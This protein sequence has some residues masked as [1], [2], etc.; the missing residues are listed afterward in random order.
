[1]SRQAVSKW[2]GG[3][4]NPDIQYVIRMSQ[5][6]GV[7]T[8]WLLLGDQPENDAAPPA[9]CPGCRA[10]VN[11]TDVFCPQ[12][13]KRLKAPPEENYRDGRFTLVIKGGEGDYDRIR[14]GLVEL[15]NSSPLP[16]DAIIPDGLVRGK[17]DWPS[18]SDLANAH[19][20]IIARNVPYETVKWAVD[21][22]QERCPILVYPEGS[23][24]TVEQLLPLAPLPMSQ[25]KKRQDPSQPLS[26]GGMV[27]AV[28]VGVI[29]ALLILSFL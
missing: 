16:E 14:G 13:G 21:L 9:R 28:I 2:E 26:F 8:D 5:L 27:A 25:S 19:A 18:M 17:A 3:Q 29:A 6:L 23:G 1:M 20:A 12:C 22:F 7:S 24:D 11:S 4:A 15:Y 10:V